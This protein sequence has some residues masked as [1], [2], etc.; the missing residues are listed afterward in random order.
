MSPHEEIASDVE[1]ELLAAAET[2]IVRGKEQG[3][4]TPEVILNAFPVLETE[5]DHVFRL[6]REMGIEITHAEDDPEE[7]ESDAGLGSDLDTM[8]SATLDD[9]IRSYLR[10]IGRVSLLTAA[11]EICLAKAI[12]AGARAALSQF[13]KPDQDAAHYLALIQAGFPEVLEKLA[14]RGDD[15][16]QM[17]GHALLGEAFPLLS[18]LLEGAAVYRRIGSDAEPLW[19][20]LNRR[21]RQGTPDFAEALGDPRFRT[22]NAAANSIGRCNKGLTGRFIE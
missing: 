15:D 20:L 14:E 7:S 8:A 18:Q 12:E 21:P 16:R 4:L 13:L 9:P 2:L 5:P 22:L 11:E 17:L 1:A 10:E 3:Y 19:R 6:F